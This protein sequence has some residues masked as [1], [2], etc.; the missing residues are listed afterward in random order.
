M[1][2]SWLPVSVWLK[3]GVVVLD[4]VL[5]ALNAPDRMATVKKDES[6]NTK[7]KG[8]A[9]VEFALVAMLFFTVLF[10]IIE[11]GYL[12]WANLTMQHAV[13]E[14]ARYA[15]VTSPANFPIP[16]PQNPATQ[17]EQ[18]C[19]AVRNA[20]ESNSMGFYARVSPVVTF[21]TIDAAGNVVNLG[22]GCGAANQ[23]IVTH[24]ACTLPLLTPMMQPFFSNGVY[25]F[26][27]SATMRN[28]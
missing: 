4:S 7:Q 23:I 8:A 6:V 25:Q 16:T 10:A 1:A 13:R 9:V 26:N 28:Q 21:R 19:N 20:I 5:A 3:C 2:Q 14:G 22:S 27:V 12:Y 24:L 17:A 11:F 15:V 18:R